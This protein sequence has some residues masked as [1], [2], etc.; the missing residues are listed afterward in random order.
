[1][2]RTRL[3]RELD[4]EPASAGGAIHLSAASGLVAAGNF[5]YVV[6]DDENHLGV[7]DATSHAPGALRKI[8]R[9]ELPREKSARKKRK[10]DLEILLRVP[11]FEAA[12]HGALLALGS[13][14]RPTRERGA[15]FALDA[16][17]ALRG[18]PNVLDLAPLYA[19]LRESLPELNLEGAVIV[20]DEFI[21][22]QR[23]SRLDPRN[24]L[25]RMPLHG[26]MNAIST[27]IFAAPKHAP[28]IETIG[29]GQAGD[30][31][32]TFTDA[33]ATDDGHILFTAVTEDT[34]DSYNDGKCLG[35]AVGCLAPDGRLVCLEPLDTAQK[36]EGLGAHR[37]GD[38][39]LLHLVTDADDAHVPAQLLEASFAIPR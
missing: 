21:L 15:W 14:S 28:R 29:L 23:A 10:A 12:P 3:I 17:G 19:T 4:L 37:L 13:G 16:D 36:V 11:A 8:F 27:S 5:F 33:T 26:L 39:Y 18:E 31:P 34:P 30:V 22:L 32:W 6:A 38:A 1:M 7:F 20:A 25:L 24:A 35:S 2:I 9:G